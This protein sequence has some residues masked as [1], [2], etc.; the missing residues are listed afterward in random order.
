MVCFLPVA[1]RTQQDKFLLQ[2]DAQFEQEHPVEDEMELIQQSRGYMFQ[3]R[4]KILAVYPLSR[5][6]IKE[7]TKVGAY[8]GFRIKLLLLDGPFKNKTI[9][10]EHY[11]YEEDRF[12]VMWKPGNKVLVGY[13]INENKQIIVPA[14]YSRDR[15]WSLLVLLAVF[16][17]A[18]IALGR[19]KGVLSLV[20]LAVTIA[21]VFVLYIPLVIQGAPPLLLA[22]L[23]SILAS[24]LT[25]LIISG[26]S[27]KTLSSSLGVVLGFLIS[28]VLVWIFGR[29]MDISGV[30]NSNIVSLGYTTDLPLLQILFSGILI[31]AVGAVMDVAISMS[32]TVQEL[33][34]ANPKYSSWQLF[35]S[36]LNVGRDLLGTMV[37]TLI[38]AYVG[39]SLPFL[40]LIFLQYKGNSPVLNILNLEVISEEILRAIIGSLGMII[41]IPST[42][43]ISSYFHPG[44]KNKSSEKQTLKKEK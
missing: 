2:E 17:G 24:L 44:K 6:E 27:F 18:V 5:Q 9:N 22:I 43:F 20:A 38:M 26:W 33:R 25:F 42:A 39:A 19:K 16:I 40:L 34:N 31:G 14:I 41:T 36:A 10:I 8:L 37:N 23:V 13:L 15:S 1:G 12:P 7:E 30:M 35:T 4:A 29:W 3:S 28:A 11:L 32:S 21:L